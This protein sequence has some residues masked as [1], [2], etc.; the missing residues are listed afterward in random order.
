MKRWR[1]Q[2]SF[3]LAKRVEWFAEFPSDVWAIIIAAY[4]PETRDGV[5]DLALMLRMM[6]TSKVMCSLFKDTVVTMLR[7]SLAVT[8]LSHPERTHYRRATDKLSM[9]VAIFYSGIRHRIDLVPYLTACMNDK[10]YHTAQHLTNC[11]SLINLASLEAGY[12]TPVMYIGASNLL[13]Y[14]YA[15][16]H[17]ADSKC[18]LHTMGYV[19]RQSDRV[20]PLTRMQNKVGRRYTL[21]VCLQREYIASIYDSSVAGI[22][23]EKENLLAMTRRSIEFDRHEFKVEGDNIAVSHHIKAALVDLFTLSGVR[24]KTQALRGSHRFADLILTSSLDGRQHHIYSEEARAFRESC[25]VNYVRNDRI[26][27]FYRLHKLHARNWSI[28]A[29]TDRFKLF[30]S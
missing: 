12:L 25:F 13:V 20:T 16:L 24:L 21:S 1:H 22:V 9:Q 11:V 8:T 28:V 29:D 4:L 10:R 23:Q 3:R 19:S 14:H 27:T 15:P 5:P 30:S 18:Y 17:E 6:G 2:Q 7:E 26:D